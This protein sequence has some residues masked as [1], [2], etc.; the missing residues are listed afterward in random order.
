MYLRHEIKV[1]KRIIFG[2]LAR[3][4]QECALRFYETRFLNVFRRLRKELRFKVGSH[5]LHCLD[6][7]IGFLFGK[8]SISGDIQQVFFKSSTN[9]LVAFNDGGSQVLVCFPDVKLG[10]IAKGSQDSCLCWEQVR[11]AS[12]RSE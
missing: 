11:L 3:S 6:A 1:A 8:V 5:S 9:V 7:I 2:T 12:A 10:I 4:A